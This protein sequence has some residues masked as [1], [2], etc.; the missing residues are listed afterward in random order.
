M[1]DAFLK[2]VAADP[3]L[4]WLASLTFGELAIGGAVAAIGALFV[5]MVARS[6]RAHGKSQIDFGR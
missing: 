6:F 5:L 4:P 1:I 3:T 2:D